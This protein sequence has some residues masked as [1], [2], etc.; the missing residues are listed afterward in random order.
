LHF[1]FF[2]S[3]FNTWCQKI[4][5]LH[6]C[7][8]IQ[9]SKFA[10]TSIQDAYEYNHDKEEKPALFIYTAFQQHER[11]ISATHSFLV[12]SLWHCKYISPDCGKNEK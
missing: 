8:I 5:F 10:G 1:F 2:G 12:G 11:R 6:A 3:S 7:R 9:P 4:A